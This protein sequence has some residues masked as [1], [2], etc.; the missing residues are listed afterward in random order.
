MAI[1]IVKFSRSSI[2][3]NYTAGKGVERTRNYKKYQLLDVYQNTTGKQQQQIIKLWHDN[4]ILPSEA[5]PAQRAGQVVIVIVDAAQHIVGVSTAYLEHRP[6]LDELAFMFRMFIR[7][8]DRRPGMMIGVVNFTFDILRGY[9]GQT[10]AA[11]LMII[12]DNRKLMRPGTRQQLG[13]MGFNLLGQEA[14]GRDVW[15][16]AFF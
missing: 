12:S 14:Q 6:Q 10:E 15:R 2:I 7:P 5:D 4:N 3:R 1:A 16:R 8:G 11:S 13:R 9:A